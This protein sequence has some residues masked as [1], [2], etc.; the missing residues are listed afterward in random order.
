MKKII[1]IGN[2]L[3]DKIVVLNDI[4]IFD[5]F[6]LKKGGMDM[7]DCQTKQRLHQAIHNHL[8]TTASGGSTANAIH[9]LARLGVPAGYIGKISNDEAGDFF[10]NDLLKSKIEP[11]LIY[12]DL[13]TGIA[14]TFITEDAER[15]FATYLGAAAT[16]S[17]DELD[18]NI[19]KNYHYILVEGYLIFNKELITKVCQL[20]KEEGLQI[21]MDMASYN[22]VE[23][24]REFIKGLLENYIDIIFANEEEAYAFTGKKEKDALMELAKYCK[25]AVVKLGG[26]GSLVSIDGKITEIDPVKSN[27]IDTNG[28]GDI[29]AAGFLYGLMKGLSAEDTGKLASVLS[30]ELVSTV[31]AKLSDEQWEEIVNHSELGIGRE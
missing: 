26:R 24:N 10:K 1:G 2:A 17:Q 14:T 27:C 13:D 20:A 21:A 6:G 15:T 19:L 12:T 11:H 30:A 31:G 22:L 25:V 28:A 9:G 23:A 18:R 29:Y 16:M 7:I 4:D 5:H 3:V 8:S